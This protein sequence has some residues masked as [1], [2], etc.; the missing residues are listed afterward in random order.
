MIRG[1]HH[2]YFDGGHRALAW[3][4]RDLLGFDVTYSSAWE[5]GTKGADRI[6]G[7]KDSSARVAMVKAGNA[8]I[9]ISIL[10]SA[11]QIR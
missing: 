7:L 5:V 3:F 4:Y 9:E 2:G 8:C 10:Q 11:A 1:I 6:T